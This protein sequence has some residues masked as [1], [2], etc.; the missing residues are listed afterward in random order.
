MTKKVVNSHGTQQKRQSWLLDIALLVILLMAVYLRFIGLNWDQNAHLHPDERFLTMVAAGVSSVSSSSEYFNTAS[1]TLNPH[2]VGFGFF[3]YGTFPLFIVRYLS[4]VFQ[5]TGYD[6]IF[7]VGRQLSA[8]ADVFTVVMVY[9][10]GNRLYRKSVGVIAAAFAAFSVVPIQQAHFFTV[11]TFANIFG[12]LTVYLAVRL[13]TSLKDRKNGDVIDWT[14]QRDPSFT[15]LISSFLPYGLFAMALGMATASKINAGVLA[16]LLPVAVL[17]RYGLHSQDW[18]IQRIIRVCI[19]LGMAGFIFFIT[20]RIL[21][22]YAFTGPSFFGILP[23]PKW[24]DNL[25]E[26]GVQSSGMADFPPALQ[27]ANRPIWFALKNTLVWGMGLPFGLTALAGFLWMAWRIIKGEWAPHILLWLWTGAYSLWQAVVWVR[28]MRYQMLIY[29][30]AA[31]LAAWVL[32]QVWQNTRNRASAKIPWLKI[33]A[34]ILIVLSIGGSFAWAFAFTRIYTRP[35]SR[36]AAS[37]WI[38]QNIPGPINLQLATGEGEYI[39]PLAY[40]AGMLV[41]ADKPY[42]IGFRA[43]SGGLLSEL[44]IPHIASDPGNASS[45]TLNVS[46][47]PVDTRESWLGRAALT[48]LFTV[49]ED[50][51]GSSHTFQ[52]MPSVTLEEGVEYL[53]VVSISAGSAGISLTGPISLTLQVDDQTSYQVLPVTVQQVRAGQ[54]YSMGFSL[55][56]SGAIKSIYLPHVVDQ[57]AMA[58]EKTLRLVIDAGANPCQGGLASSMTGGSFTAGS[59]PRGGGAS[60]QFDQPLELDPAVVH[61]LQI[62]LVNGEGAI[63][64]YGSAPA[65]ESSWDDAIPYPVNGINAY[66]GDQYSGIYRGDLNFELYWDDTQTK[67]DLFLTTLDQADTIFIS[68]NRQ[69][70]T[71][72]RIPERYPLTSAYY[73]SLLGCPEGKELVWCYNIAEPGMFSGEFGFELAETFTS[74][75]NLGALQFNDQFAEEAFSVYDHP[76]V[77]IFRKTSDYDP[78]RVREI[79]TAVNISNII[80]L[81]PKDAGRI[82]SEK[83]LMLPEDR[84]DAQQAGG[85]W[86]ELFARDSLINRSPILGILAWYLVVSLLG[87]FCYPLVRLAFPG[88]NDRGYPLSRI[89]GLLLLAIIVWL[90]GSAG[91]PYTKI[92]ISL[93]LAGIALVGLTF[94]YIQRKSLLDDLKKQWKNYLAVEIVALGL[95]LIF[96]AVRLGNPDLWHPSKGGEKPMDFSY[97]NAVLKSTSFPP[98]DPWLSG[99]YINYYYYGFVIVGTLVKWLGLIPSFAYNLI[100]PTLFSL[101]GLGAYS[102]GW[103]LFSA[104]GGYRQHSK[105]FGSWLPGLTGIAAVLTTGILGNLATVRMIW[106][107]L[108]RLAAPGGDILNSNIF[109][110]IAWTFSG[111]LAYFKSPIMPYYPGDWYWI[112]SR[113]ISDGPITEFPAFSFLYAD[114]HAHLIALPV[115]L[116]ALSWAISIVLGKSHWGEKDGRH[117]ILSLVA[118]F[119]F[120]A[121]AIGALRPTNTWD[122]PTYLVL[123]MAALIYSTIKYGLPHAREKVEKGKIATR[124]ALAAVL[125]GVLVLS[126]QNLYQP[127]SQW[128]ARTVGSNL[129]TGETTPFWSY[130]SHWGLFLFVIV[131]WLGWETYKWMDTTPLKVVSDWRRH[132]GWF[133]LAGAVALSAF[134]VSTFM[135]KLEIGWLVLLL[136]IWIVFLLSVAKLSDAKRIVLFLTGTALTLTLAVELIVLKDDIGRMNTVFK[137]YLQAWTL[138]AVSTAAAFT[139]TIQVINKWNFRWRSI[140]QA[141]VMVLI[142]GAA[143]FPLTAARDKIQDRMAPET[144]PSLDGMT[145]MQYAVY[146]DMGLLMY[147]ESD[148]Y[149]IQW[150]QDNIKGSPVIVEGNTPE[151]RW[152]SRFTIYTGLPG[153]VGWNWHQRQQ[154]AVQ[155]ETVVTQRIADISEFYNTV[156]RVMA[157]GFLKKYDVSYIVVGQLEKAYYPGAGLDKFPL[158]KNALWRE[159]YN[160]G[161]TAIYEVMKD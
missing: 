37:E 90:A 121:I 51:R 22:P 81:L 39:Q 153:V 117:F 20:F 21:Q 128:Y 46:I 84:L 42:L 87:W 18:P 124:I 125:A 122:Y 50:L 130:L 7:L 45:T 14:T 38:M 92:T 159:V 17:V 67:L 108:M 156:N 41:E 157:M 148:Y 49:S 44:T 28:A 77:L 158:W 34:V 143:L 152:G 103:N 129:W 106:H 66:A 161:L 147:L 73:R 115:T 43:Q 24:L 62:C 93:V 64:I 47:S 29:P 63:A 61:T 33:F 86:S 3:V 58:G 136:G 126:A 16:F 120:G 2:N 104:G 70:G 140:W 56:R 25:K 60:F 79:L 8:L 89:A 1:S 23:N 109:E 107:G 74:Y 32:N 110:R 36:L 133:Y 160:D 150:M 144:P 151:Y 105:P 127:F 146:D 30:S 96:L 75:P 94:G 72:T 40:R 59:D 48:D 69:W 55:V 101:L 13:A 12:F 82:I 131:I 118:G 76:K 15:S 10:I 155:Q 145:Y 149:A 100:L 112:P 27:W 11:D 99:G 31:I 102:V 135:F 88:L 142:A 113:A 6:Q 5:K 139:W 138:F 137:F 119:I 83:S 141:G 53:I 97:F 132:A 35:V 78:R 111:L 80:H 57:T 26:L 98:Y 91:V 9:L 123:S 71:T 95:F 154:R 134:I 19:Y 52:F 54:P 4:E 116:F 85:T 65:N 114:L 68:S